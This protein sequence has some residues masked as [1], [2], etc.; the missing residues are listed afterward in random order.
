MKKGWILF[1]FVL[2]SHIVTGQQQTTYNKKGDEAMARE[3]YREA[4]MWYEEGVINCDLYSIDKITQIWRNQSSMRVSM[5]S[6]ITKCYDCLTTKSAENDTTAIRNLIYYHKEGIGVPENKTLASYWTQRLAFLSKD[7]DLTDLYERPELKKDRESNFFI[8]YN[9][10]VEAPFGLTFGSVGKTMGW[11]ARIKSNL[12]FTGYDRDTNNQG[13]SDVD[14]QFRFEK[15]KI[16]A[17]IGTA[18]VIFKWS[19]QIHSSIGLGYGVRELLWYYSI[20]DD[21]KKSS[22]GWSKNVE[23]SHKGLVTELDV[24]WSFGSMFISVGGHSVNFKY[25]DLNAGVGV[26]F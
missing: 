9:Y 13:L 15:S 6:L 11:Y 1:A 25:V 16:N 14:S 2:I 8:G 17:H 10:S 19:D 4:K 12:S 22:E 3:D 7:A 20:Y 18:G 21:D 26:Y 24:I 5:R 23:A